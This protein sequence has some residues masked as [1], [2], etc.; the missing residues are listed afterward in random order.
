VD[1]F[2]AIA[3]IE[4]ANAELPASKPADLSRARLVRSLEAILDGFILSRSWDKVSEQSTCQIAAP[5]R[6]ESHC[7]N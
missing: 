7:V 2:D 6:L 1:I 5:N 4:D 3:G